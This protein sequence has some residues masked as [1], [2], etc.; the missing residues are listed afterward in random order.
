MP[1]V[2]WYEMDSRWYAEYF[3]H[4]TAHPM[5][6][7]TCARDSLSLNL[8]HGVELMRVSQQAKH[9]TM[10]MVDM[11][12]RS[13]TT[14]YW[15]W[16]PFIPWL[17]YMDV[18]KRV[19]VIARGT[20]GLHHLSMPEF[21]HCDF[22]IRLLKEHMDLMTMFVRWRDVTVTRHQ[23]R[24]AELIMCLLH[25]HHFRVIDVLRDRVRV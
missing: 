3:Q 25:L 10:L 12:E 6:S 1:H 14:L 7:R 4:F 2:D 13:E 18:V 21:E 24:R 15:L 23:A 11:E 8:E 16:R 22:R 20:E 5:A 17:G 9:R 19:A